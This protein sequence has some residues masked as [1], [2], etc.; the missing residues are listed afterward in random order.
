M[1]S[2]IYREYREVVYV[3]N[4]NNN[5]N[6]NDNSNN[7]NNNCNW[8]PSATRPTQVANVLLRTPEPKLAPKRGNREG[9]A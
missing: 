7:N 1:G 5:N 6:N 2:G 4:N 3:T 8:A 9:L